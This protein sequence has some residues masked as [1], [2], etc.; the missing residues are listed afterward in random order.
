MAWI[1][2]VVSGLVMVGWF[3]E[4]PRLVQLRADLV[5][6]RFNTALGL[7]LV[8][9]ALLVPARWRPVPAGAA[10]VLM[11]LIL[12]QYVAGVDRRRRRAVR[13]RLG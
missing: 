2:I 5:A 10:L 9:A 7:M 3:V 11:L 1:A 8:S 12:V 4:E 13:R 6:M